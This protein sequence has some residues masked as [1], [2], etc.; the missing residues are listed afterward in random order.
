ME[1]EQQKWIYMRIFIYSIWFSWA[2]T[3]LSWSN[4][5]IICRRMSD[6]ALFKSKQAVFA[7][8]ENHRVPNVQGWYLLHYENSSKDWLSHCMNTQLYSAAA[9]SAQETHWSR[10]TR[11]GLGEGKLSE[12]CR[13][14]ALF[15]GRG[16]FQRLHS[17]KTLSSDKAN[18]YFLCFCPPG[19]ALR[20]FRMIPIL[21]WGKESFLTHFSLTVGSNC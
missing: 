2:V 6:N 7:V 20:E 9:L 19:Y 11:G 10:A 12:L 15:Q 4:P 13:T 1:K 5:W 16:H 17:W 14:T 8:R 18:L 21:V 3:I